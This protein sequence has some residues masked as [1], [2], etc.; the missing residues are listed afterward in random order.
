VVEGMKDTLF[1]NSVFCRY[2]N[3]TAGGYS[4][5][6]M[7]WKPNR[8]VFTKKGPRLEDVFYKFS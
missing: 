3:G 6:H 5:R 7:V 8:L 1:K 2:V 4:R